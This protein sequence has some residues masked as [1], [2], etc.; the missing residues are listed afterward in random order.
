[1]GTAEEQIE[2]M[3]RKLFEK[4]KNKIILVEHYFMSSKNLVIFM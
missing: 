4:E 1:M 2:K 3:T